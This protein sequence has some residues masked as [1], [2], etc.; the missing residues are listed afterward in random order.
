MVIAFDLV[1]FVEA[2]PVA[3]SGEGCIEE[4]LNHFEGGGRGD[5]AGAEGEDVGVVVFAGELGG[6]DIVGQ[7]AADAGD[8]V[9]GDGNPNARAADSDTE[10]SF[11]RS[12]AFAYGFAKIRIVHGVLGAGALVV[13]QVSRFLEIFSDGFFE[14]ES[15]V[16]GTN[17]D[18]WFCGRMGHRYI[19]GDC[20]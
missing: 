6:D 10:I 12:N 5:D 19:R 17:G 18:A 11:L 7:G 1:D 16:I 13:D 3:A 2:A 15:G 9:G 8:F 20:I 4:S 14:R